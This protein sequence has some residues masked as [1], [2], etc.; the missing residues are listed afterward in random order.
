MGEG[1]P[2]AGSPAVVPGTL[3]SG[4]GGAGWTPAGG[5][6]GGS[7]VEG[8]LTLLL[9]DRTVTMVRTRPRGEGGAVGILGLPRHRKPPNTTGPV[10]HHRGKV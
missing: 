1:S 2:S 8:G 9:A 5:G 6:G 7:E 10:P 4:G 3:W